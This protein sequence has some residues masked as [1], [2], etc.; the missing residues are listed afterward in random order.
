MHFKTK[1]LYHKFNIFIV[2]LE[3]SLPVALRPK[4]R[5]LPDA[6]VGQ[7]HAAASQPVGGEPTQQLWNVAM[8]V[9]G[10]CWLCDSQED[11]LDPREHGVALA[12]LQALTSSSWYHRKAMHLEESIWQHGQLSQHMKLRHKSSSTLPGGDLAQ[13]RKNPGLCQAAY[14]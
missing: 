6:V 13:R 12:G 7:V 8:A 2:F 11:L 4:V 3:T 10:C 5:G 1:I 9:A 14:L